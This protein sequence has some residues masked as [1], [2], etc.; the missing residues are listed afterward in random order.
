MLGF[1]G[2]LMGARRSPSLSAA[3]GLWTPDEQVISS[4]LGEWPSSTSDP[5][6]NNVSLLLPMNGSNG[7]TT[8]TDVS[9]NA[10]T[11]TVNGNAQIS[12]AQSKWG[13]SSGYFDGSGDYLTVASS[14]MDVGDGNFTIECWVRPTSIPSGLSTLWG[15]RSASFEIGGALLVSGGSSGELV[16]YVANSSGSWGLSGTSAGHTLVADTWQHLAM[17]RDGSTITLYKG[18]NAGTPATFTGTVGT[19]G[20]F[21]IMAGTSSGTQEVPGYVNDFRLTK[22]IAR[23]TANFTPPAEPFPTR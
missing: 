8:F 18:G 2:G 21:S 6:W 4:R 13:G 11:V 17:V 16:F 12:T 3:S 5:Y 22:G 10:L 19:S 23:Y 7:S 1:N 14:L 15:H 9:S 20:S